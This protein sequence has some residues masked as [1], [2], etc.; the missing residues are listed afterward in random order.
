[1]RKGTSKR[2]RGPKGKKENE[3]EDKG[4]KEEVKGKEIWKRRKRTEQEGTENKAKKM[5]KR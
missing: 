2:K 5:I 1:M 3:E 4:E